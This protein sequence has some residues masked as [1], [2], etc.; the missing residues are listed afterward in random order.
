MPPAS[1]QQQKMIYVLRGKYKNKKNTPQKHKWVWEEGFS[2]P[3]DEHK[4]ETYYYY[5]ER[6]TECIIKIIEDIANGVEE[7]PWA[8]IQ[9]PLVKRI[10][11]EFTRV[12]LIRNEKGLQKI[13]NRVIDTII[14][15]DANCMIWGATPINP[16]EEIKSLE[17]HFAKKKPEGEEE[18][19]PRDP[20]QLFLFK[21]VQD[22]IKR[23]EEEDD[24]IDGVK[25]SITWEEF[26]EKITD[27]IK[28][29]SDF[30]REPLVE[31][32]LDLLSTYDSREQ[33]MLVDKAFNVVHQ[34]YDLTKIFFK[35]GSSDYSELSG[36]NF[37]DSSETYIPEYKSF[38]P[39]FESP[40]EI[41]TDDI[42]VD[43][44]SGNVFAFL[45][46][47]GKIQVGTDGME[48]A[49]IIAT[50]HND[51]MPSPDEGAPDND[52]IA[53]ANHQVK[54]TE[55]YHSDR[56]QDA[57]RCWANELI[58]SFWLTKNFVF[59]LKT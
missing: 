31:I 20:D 57:G 5:D 45:Y 58:I 11:E 39:L 52:L 56:V 35:N 27:Y 7:Q 19:Q 8:F 2:E 12:G 3:L 46:L 15:L 55:I 23:K 13:V 40:V 14:K 37:D 36:E 22:D 42:H 34:Q 1:R 51:Y 44:Q 28:F 33:I 17:Y 29:V 10:W 41:N 25:L 53:W 30:G 16:K 18:K 48:H 59:I 21:D 50:A 47:D 24:Y 32:A 6:Y 43:I 9:L 49:D 38:I 4:Q 26:D 54:Y